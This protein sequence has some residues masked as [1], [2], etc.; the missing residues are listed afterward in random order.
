MRG[1]S[2]GP[3]LYS[4]DGSLGDEFLAASVETVDLLP[5]AGTKAHFIDF[6]PQH[7][8]VPD[9][10]QAYCIISLRAGL[11]R[12]RSLQHREIQKLLLIGG[13]R[14]RNSI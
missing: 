11:A 13:S 6:V 8:S 4:R 5:A 7:L 2:P 10:R 3:F 9:T 14:C 12:V 1:G